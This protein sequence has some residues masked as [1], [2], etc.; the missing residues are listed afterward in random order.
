VVVV[1]DVVVVGEELAEF[2]EQ[3][4]STTGSV[5]STRVKHFLESLIELQ[6]PFASTSG[7]DSAVAKL[8]S[9]RSSQ[10]NVVCQ[11]AQHC[12]EGRRLLL[13]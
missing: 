4:A 3:P 12:F 13:E 5:A 10:S 2:D 1:S 8:R 6:Y 7:E 11:R 9:I